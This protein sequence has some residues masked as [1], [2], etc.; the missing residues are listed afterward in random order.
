MP[1]RLFPSTSR[2]RRLI[3][4]AAW[5]NVAPN[6]AL[7]ELHLRFQK[8]QTRD[9]VKK[10]DDRPGEAPVDPDRPPSLIVGDQIERYN[11]ISVIKSFLGPFDL[12]T[13]MEVALRDDPLTTIYQ[14][15]LP[16]PGGKRMYPANLI[17]PSTTER[18]N[19]EP[20]VMAFD[21]S[22]MIAQPPTPHSLRPT[23]RQT[24]AE[25]YQANRDSREADQPAM[26]RSTQWGIQDDTWDDEEVSVVDVTHILAN[27]H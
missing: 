9:N 11:N 18:A 19:M 10:R 16:F 1:P 12:A 6:A 15:A 17:C 24:I 20:C 2:Q 4:V 13:G 14:K 3:C 23:I 25:S 27:A 22:G 26:Y 8:K 7:K 5:I 21:I